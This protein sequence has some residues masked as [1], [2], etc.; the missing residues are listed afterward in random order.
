MWN[1][2]TKQLTIYQDGLKVSQTTPLTTSDLDLPT[3]TRS[4]FDLG[5][6][7]DYNQVMTG[8]LRELLVFDR[9]VTIEEVNI[10]QGN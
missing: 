8:W 2:E 4:V 3:P 9:A 10:I 5:Y 7:R 6:K 1:R